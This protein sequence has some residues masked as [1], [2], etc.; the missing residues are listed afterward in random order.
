MSDVL[1]ALKLAVDQGFVDSHTNGGNSADTLP[2]PE[3]AWPERQQLTERPTA[4]SLPERMIPAPFQARVRDVATRACIPLEMVACPIINAAGAVVGRQMGIRPSRN[5]N[6]IVVPNLWGGVIARPGAMKTYGIEEAIKPLKA[7][8]AKARDRY[9]AAVEA[10]SSRQARIKAEID[11]I[12]SEMVSAAK[13][14]GDKTLDELEKDLTTKQKELQE[15]GV[16]ERR[17]MTQDA[18]LE[19]LGELLRDN[20][21]GLLVYRDELAGWLHTLD[22][23]GREGDREFYLEAWNGTGSYTTDRIGRGTIHIPATCIS[24]FG[25]IQPGKLNAYVREAIAGAE[26]ADGLLQRIQLMVWPDGLGKWEPPDRPP[27]REA[28]Y[29]VVEI[30]EWLDAINPDLFEA[31]QETE[32]IPVIRFSPKAQQLFDQ[33]R[34]ELEYRVRSTELESAPAF[35]AHISKYRSLMP[36]L[37]LL[38]HLIDVADRAPPG[39][40]SLA[41]AQL[42]A[43]WCDYLEAHAKKVYAAELYPGMEGAYLLA[44]KIEQGVITD[45]DKVRDIYALHHW[46]GLDTPGQVN[47]ALEK[48]QEAG[49]VRVEEVET[50]GRPTQVLR[51]H[52]DLRAK[53]ND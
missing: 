8:A 48:L 5:D 14:R 4:P 38:F 29:R 40:V 50:G 46:S 49:W 1:K 19:K 13:G 30:F 34:T 9:Q 23:A 52:P 11:A 3:G 17:Y 31:E 6:Y 7:L 53:A 20:P 12:K 45:G 39:P 28:Y 25:G 43:S 10:N 36:S 26:G 2:E 47:A 51:V 15:N 35:E 37:A 16:I 24:I 22:R 32:S 18:T 42:A 27:D 33:W 21:R 44:K 41:A